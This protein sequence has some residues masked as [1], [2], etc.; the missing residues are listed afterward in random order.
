MS[1]LAIHTKDPRFHDE[2]WGLLNTRGSGSEREAH[3]CTD[4][5]LPTFTPTGS[6]LPAVSLLP[7]QEQ[8]GVT[9]GDR[10]RNFTGQVCALIQP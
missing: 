8:G 7:M 2:T 4:M 9:D 6:I 5:V 1:A 10:E 3:T